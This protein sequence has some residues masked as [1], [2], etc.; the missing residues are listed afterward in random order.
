MSYSLRSNFVPVE[1]FLAELWPL[2]LYLFFVQILSCPDFFFTSFE[3]LTWY[4][5][6]GYIEMSYSLSLNFIP[7]EIAVEET[8]Y[9]ANNTLH[10]LYFYIFYT[11]LWL[12]SVVELNVGGIPYI[13]RLETLRRYPQSMLGAMFSRRQKLSKASVGDTTVLYRTW[14]GQLGRCF[15][16]LKI[17]TKGP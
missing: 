16:K 17:W 13:T 1:W 3:I 11:F 12:P 5:V 6:C 10:V 15:L 2:N 7:V 9:K 4:L 8:N 14:L